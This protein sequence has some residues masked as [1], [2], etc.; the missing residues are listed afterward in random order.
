MMNRYGPIPG[1]WMTGFQS[2][3][4]TCRQTDCVRSVRKVKIHDAML[5]SISRLIGFWKRIGC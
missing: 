5:G 2:D 4:V 1:P 3:M